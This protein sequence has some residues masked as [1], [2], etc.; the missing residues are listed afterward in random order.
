MKKRLSRR[1]FVKTSVGVPTLAMIGETIAPQAPAPGGQFTPLDL[2]R[3]FNR[4]ASFATPAGRQSFWAFPS[5]CGKS[6]SSRGR[7][8]WA[9]RRCRY[10]SGRRRPTCAC[11]TSARAA[12]MTRRFHPNG[13]AKSSPNTCWFTLTAPSTRYPSAA[14]SRFRSPALRGASSRL[15]PGPIARIRR[16][17]STI[18]FLP[19]SRGGTCKPWWAGKA[20]E[21]PTCGCAR[22]R[23]RIPSVRF[24][25]C[26]WRA[27]ARVKFPSAALRSIMTPSRRCFTIASAFSASACRCRI[28]V[29]SSAGG[30]RWTWASSPAPTCCRNSPPR[31]GSNL[32][33]RAWGNQG[34]R[35]A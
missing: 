14:G 21:V 10:P 27:R 4:A 9:T 30:C 28:R 32:R 34:R 12:A 25:P 24:A 15:P 2:A 35:R 20:R 18:R 11:A 33:G 22:S 31:N 13:S 8:L 16:A 26:V 3:H 19:V 7:S 5:C 17:G 23:I 1:T 6:G 29:S